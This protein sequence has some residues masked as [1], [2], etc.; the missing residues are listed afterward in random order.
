MRT[1]LTVAVCLGIASFTQAQDP[2]EMARLLP[3][4]S[5]MLAIVRVGEILKS[6][7]A[8][9]EDWE[10][11]ANDKFLSGGGGIP[12]WVGTLV[13]GSR[14]RL[15]TGEELWSSAIA[16]VPKDVTLEQ[17]AKS[18][19]GTL[20]NGG[21]LTML[22]TPRDAYITALTGSLLAARRPAVRQ[23]A[24][25]WFSNAK[26]SST[27][28]RSTFL[29]Q[30]SEADDH[31][32]L[33][34]E[35]TNAL[36]PLNFKKHLEALPEFK[37]GTSLSSLLTPAPNARQGI[38]LQINIAREIQ[39]EASVDFG[40]PI[41]NLGPLL[42]AFVKDQLRQSGAMIDE[43]AAATPVV[44]GNSLV[45][46]STLTDD[47]LRRILSLITSFP[48]HGGEPAVAAAAPA[49]AAPNT[50]R[51]PAEDPVKK[52]SQKY[53]AAVNKLL[54]DLD[55]ANRKATNYEQTAAWHV[56][57]AKRMEDLATANVDPA[58]VDYSHQVAGELRGLSRS[59]QGEQVTVN[60]QQ[61]SLTYNA[62]YTPGWASVNIWGGVGVGEAAYNVQSNL[63][64]VREK[65][66][67]AV[68]AGTQQREQIWQIINSQRT[69][70]NQAMR[71]K[72]GEDF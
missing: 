64:Q 51:A 34:L 4:D 66:A 5:N 3:P 27:G 71:T 18:A 2:V 58:L 16:S 20:E 49:A 32:V 41:G 26:D 31:I 65:Q 43:F 61:Q 59:L 14:V 44:E 36:D 7:R 53:L 6:P 69:A 29:R 39:A 28:L 62:Q 25:E 9:A 70:I 67:S 17:L 45:F 33:S 72:F 48:S 55:R 68:A 47:S 12:P 23:E 50:V 56:R 40:S 10:K 37:A 57:Y 46:R 13:V 21:S 15:S 8:V 54:D 38:I 60:A 1:L 19:G 42:A 63:A 22:R 11:S 52:A 24:V 35:L 30:A